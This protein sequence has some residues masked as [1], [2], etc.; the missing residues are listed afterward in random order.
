[1]LVA[2]KGVVLSGHRDLVRKLDPAFESLYKQKCLD[3]KVN[4]HRIIDHYHVQLSYAIKNDLTRIS[5]DCCIL[6]V[7]GR[8][9]VSRFVSE[10]FRLW[11]VSP[12]VVSPWVVSPV[13]CFAPI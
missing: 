4:R 2:V 3:W 1:M 13:S 10:S 6:S 8:S 11:V 9:P 5:N 12:W 7:P